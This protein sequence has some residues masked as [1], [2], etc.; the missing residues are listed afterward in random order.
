MDCSA[1]GTMINNKEMS[2]SSVV[3]KHN[4][5]FTIGERSFRYED[6]KP[7]VNLYINFCFYSSS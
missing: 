7:E 2:E 6:T 1:N 4:D 3:L 5:S